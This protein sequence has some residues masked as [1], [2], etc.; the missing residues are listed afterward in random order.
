MTKFFFKLKKPY[1]WLLFSQFFGK[2]FTKK[3]SLYH[4]YLHKDYKHHAKILQNLMIQ[5]QENT[6]TDGRMEGWTDPTLQD[7]S[8]YYRGSNRYKC[9]TLAFKSQRYR[10]A[11]Q[12]NQKL[13]HR[14]SQSASKKTQLNS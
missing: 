6:R 4:T 9:S 11:C 13:L 1:F 7:P 5:F 12:S 8:S 3:I 14:P 10:V 2:V